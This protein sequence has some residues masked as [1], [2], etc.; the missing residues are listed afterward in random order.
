MAR[1]GEK[2]KLLRDV[3]SGFTTHRTGT[4]GEV[5]KAAGPF[6]NKIRI[7][8]TGFM[9]GGREVDVP[10]DAIEKDSGW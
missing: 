9:E 6:S 10:E 1:E 5:V 3:V 8:L 4:K 2:V 7:R